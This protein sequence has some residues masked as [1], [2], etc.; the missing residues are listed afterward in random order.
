MQTNICTIA[1]MFYH[2]TLL[3]SAIVI[4]LLFQLFGKGF[5]I[6]DSGTEKGN[7]L[8]ISSA[9][10]KIES[11]TLNN[12]IKAMVRK[13]NAYLSLPIID[14][15]QKYVCVPLKLILGY[16]VLFML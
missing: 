13:G 10:F 4:V 1:S 2:Q 12:Y 7:N 5:G 3:F 16:F 15:P 8:V 11:G 6:R 9:L 14:G